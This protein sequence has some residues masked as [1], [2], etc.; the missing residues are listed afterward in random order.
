[1]QEQA[2]KHNV[3]VGWMTT[4]ASYTNST[5]LNTKLGLKSES[6]QKETQVYK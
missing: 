6:K 2:D 3:G 1:M 5:E 4:I